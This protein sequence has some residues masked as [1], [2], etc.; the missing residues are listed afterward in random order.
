MPKRN[1]LKLFGVMWWGRGPPVKPEDDGGRGGRQDDLAIT[2]SAGSGFDP[3]PTSPFQVEEFVVGFIDDN[4]E[5]PKVKRRLALK[6]GR[7]L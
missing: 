1:R 7:N 2:L 3:L 5:P 4:R 6:R